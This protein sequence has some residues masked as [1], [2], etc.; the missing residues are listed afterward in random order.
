MRRRVNGVNRVVLLLLGLVLLAAGVAGLAVS[1]G[2]VGDSTDPVLP[3]R[4]R[5]YP[6]DQPWF[7]WA[8]AVGCLVLA[9]LGLR[10]LFA[11]LATDRVGRLDLT[12]DDR[13]GLT[14]VHAGGFSDAVEEEVERLRGVA[15]ASAHLRD[16]GGRRLVLTVDLAD[17]ADIAE[18]RRALEDRTVGHARQAVDDP[19]LPVDIRLR[20]GRA[21]SASRGLV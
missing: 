5:T 14:T 2:L 17:Y 16:E 15:G 20:P 18:I 12:V 7:W 8:V 1:F 9:L 6:D 19:D 11:Q 13:D 10:W 4:V 21:R 3:D